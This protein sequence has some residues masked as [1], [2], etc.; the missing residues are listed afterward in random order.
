ML[1][2]T[3]CG[4]ITGEVKEKAVE[5]EATA[6]EV[7]EPTATPLPAEATLTPPLQPTEKEGLT[8]ADVPIWSTADFQDTMEGLE[9]PVYSEVF[10][11]DPETRPSYYEDPQSLSYIKYLDRR[12]YNSGIFVALAYDFGEFQ[13]YFLYGRSLPKLA[14]IAEGALTLGTSGTSAQLL[15]EARF[16]KILTD[17][18]GKPTGVEVEEFHY[19]LDGELIFTSKSQFDLDGFKVAEREVTGEKEREYYFIWPVTGY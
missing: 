12:L 9:D 5:L 18:N 4:G 14:G 11:K 3:A 10:M 13:N 7:I 15:A 8:K 19:G 1:F 6:K 2:L 16:L 17:E